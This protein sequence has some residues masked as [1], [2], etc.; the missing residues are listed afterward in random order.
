M[1][2]DV[3]VRSF[4]PV[5]AMGQGDQASWV[6][7]E[8]PVCPMSKLSTQ[9]AV[10]LNAELDLG[11]ALDGDAYTMT[12]SFALRSLD[13]SFF[14]EMVIALAEQADMLNSAIEQ[15]VLENA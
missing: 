14:V 15:G 13:G 5:A 8:C 11:L 6:A 10:G 2:K 4:V 7:L 1:K 12:Q 9:V 3:R